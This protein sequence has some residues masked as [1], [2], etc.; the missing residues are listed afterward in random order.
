[1][2]GISNRLDNT[3]TTHPHPGNCPGRGLPALRLRTSIALGTG[4][5]SSFNIFVLLATY[6]G[7]A[8]ASAVVL[9]GGLAERDWAT[10]MWLVIAIA[11]ALP[12][13]G[14]RDRP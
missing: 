4:R 12:R 13:H 3:A 1:M 10:L 7:A 8:N 9:V 5:L 2:Y 6:H 11:N 14:L